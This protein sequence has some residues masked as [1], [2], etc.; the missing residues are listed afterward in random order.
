MK[1]RL[2]EIIQ[3]RLFIFL[4]CF[5]LV[6]SARA[7]YLIFGNENT[8]IEVGLNFGPTFFRGDLGSKGTNFIKDP[9]YSFTKLMKGAFIS[10]Y[11]NEWLGFRLA[12]QY[13]YLEGIDSIGSTHGENELW[14]KQRN[15]DFKSN[16]WEV[17]SAAEFFPLQY[18]RREEDEYDPRFRPYI[19]AGVGLFHFNPKGSLRDQDGN[20]TWHELQPLHTEGQGFAE[21]P[22][23]KNYKLT[24]INLPYGAGVKYLV[25]GNINL[26]LEFLYRKTFTD[27][28]DDVSTKYIDP[29]Y[30]DKYLTP[31]DALIANKI[32]DKIIGTVVPGAGR[33]APGNIRGNT[34]RK[35]AY[36]SF[37]LKFSLTLGSNNTGYGGYHNY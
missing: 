15:L 16:M 34:N 1:T 5:I 32:S 25:S 31:A 27:Y 7:Q 2:H 13:T 28:I 18:I 10:V 23:R 6:S 14:R 37:L 33:Y 22:G 24:Q 36:F 35:D 17:Y 19:F 8:T 26:G 9:N 11:P 30:F 20:V 29:I 12:A 21:Y 3:K 4:L